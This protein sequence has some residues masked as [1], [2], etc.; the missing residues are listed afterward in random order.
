MLLFLAC[1]VGVIQNIDDFFGT[2]INDKSIVCNTSFF[3][4]FESTKIM[5]GAIKTD[6]CYVLLPTLAHSDQ[7]SRSIDFPTFYLNWC[8]VIV[9]VFFFFAFFFVSFFTCLA[10]PGWIIQCIGDFFVTFVNDKSIVCH[11]SFFFCFECTKIMS[12]ATNLDRCCVFLPTLVHSDQTS[13]SIAC[14]TFLLSWHG[15][16]FFF[17]FFSF[18]FIR[19]LII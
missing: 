4:C 16:F 3:F 2:F 6:L 5:L 15:F 10:C 11:T 13:L 1:S 9:I 8:I 18:L 19:V 17:F 12:C 7:T 14:F